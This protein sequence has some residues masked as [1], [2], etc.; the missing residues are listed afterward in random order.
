MTLKGISGLLEAMQQSPTLPRENVVEQL[1][2]RVAELTDDFDALTI[3]SFL[4]GVRAVRAIVPEEVL[5]DIYGRAMV[6]YWSV[7]DADA[8]LE[9]MAELRLSPP[10]EVRER[11]RM[12][13][14]GERLPKV[15]A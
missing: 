14:D 10:D 3:P 8:C 15:A 13:A 2:E 12:A 7:E 6:I 9:A 1:L 5:V 4:R 11:L